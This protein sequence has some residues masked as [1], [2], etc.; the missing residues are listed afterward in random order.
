LALSFLKKSESF[1]VYYHKMR[2]IAVNE[3]A[4]ALILGD[5]ISFSSLSQDVRQREKE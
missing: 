4:L 3:Y 1:Y 2:E 5:K